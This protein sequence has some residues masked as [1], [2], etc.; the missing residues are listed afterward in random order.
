[1]G[2]LGI[3]YA[4]KSKKALESLSFVGFEYVG[5]EY[6]YKYEDRINNA[7]IKYDQIFID[8]AQK[9][10]TTLKEMVEKYDKLH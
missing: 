9:K 6:R 3:Q 8:C 4:V 5:V 7:N 10:G 2:N 1:M